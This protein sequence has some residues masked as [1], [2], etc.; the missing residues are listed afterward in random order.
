MG[1]VD[2]KLIFFEKFGGRK[3]LKCIQCGTCSAS[4]PL[5]AQMDHAPR[6]LFALIRDGE[7]VTAL[8]SK[9]LW[10]CVSCYY[11]I[12]RCPQ[13]IPVTDLIYAL[14]QMAVKHG[15]C[16]AEHKLPDMYNSFIR[17]VERYGRVNE[18][19]LMARYA[20][21]HPE[22]ALGSLPM[23]LRMFIKRRLDLFPSRVRQPD[24]IARLLAE[25][26]RQETP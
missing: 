13:E 23:A 25:A 16:P 14:K 15:L 22:D 18:P 17:V 19:V 11:C 2:L 26:A 21:S 8:R 12:V 10:Y 20:L 6:E 4:C 9:S 1:E 3:I 5:S 24:R 7:I